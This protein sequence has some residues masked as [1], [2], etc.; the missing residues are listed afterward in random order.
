MFLYPSKVHS[1]NW[2]LSVAKTFTCSQFTLQIRQT[3][4]DN[5]IRFPEGGAPEKNP[6]MK[7]ENC[8]SRKNIQTYSI[9]SLR[10]STKKLHFWLHFRG[11]LCFYFDDS[12]PNDYLSN[13]TFIVFGHWANWTLT[14]YHK[15]NSLLSY[16]VKMSLSPLLT[17]DTQQIE[18][19][20]NIKKETHHF[21]F[22]V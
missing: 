14:K 2:S 9:L 19:L 11:K 6:D 15:R 17:L 16:L 5:Y 10:N 21:R 3:L 18:L 12:D 4:R 8:I 20:E 22:V 1:S 7:S 13:V